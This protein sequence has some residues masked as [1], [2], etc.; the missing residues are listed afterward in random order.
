MPLIKA[1]EAAFQKVCPCAEKVEQ[2]P[3]DEKL[4]ESASP[5]ANSFPEKFI[6]ILPC[7]F[8]EIK[9]SCF[10]ALIPINGWNQ[11]VKCVAPCS[12]AQF[13]ISLAIILHVSSSSVKFSWTECLSLQQTFSGKRFL[14]TSSSKTRQPKSSGSFIIKVTPIKN[15]KI[16][17][18]KRKFKASF[19]IIRYI[20]RNVT[21][22]NFKDKD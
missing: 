21:C 18:L 5:L 10:S 13:F 17:T 20:S 14:I 1:L 6:I 8:L 2:S 9:L 3:P 4:E 12:I 19:I 22:K 16:K 11:C 7:S 15:Y